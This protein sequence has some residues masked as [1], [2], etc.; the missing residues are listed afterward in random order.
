MICGAVKTRPSPQPSPSRERGFLR[1]PEPEMRAS[2]YAMSG[3]HVP[4][5]LPSLV[6]ERG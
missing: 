5:K 3:L 2:T 1:S 6:R 4:E